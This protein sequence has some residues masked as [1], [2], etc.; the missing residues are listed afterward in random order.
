MSSV[1]SGVYPCYKNQFEIDGKAIANA[2][3]FQVSI[4]NGVEEWNSFDQEGWKSRLMTAKSVTIS[5][6]CKR[7]IGDEGNDLV[8]KTAWL[9]GR[10]VEKPFTWNMPDGTKITFNNA[11]ISVTELGSGESTNAAPL[12]FDVMSNGKPAITEPSNTGS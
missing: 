4:D 2:V 7:T 1:T 5:V 10:E 11:V 9:N 12:S 8:A 6:S 3:T